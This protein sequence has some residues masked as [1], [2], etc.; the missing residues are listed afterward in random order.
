MSILVDL[1]RLEAALA[2]FGAGYLLTASPEGAVKAVTV[3]PRYAGGR[4][5][6]AGSRGS[7]ANLAAN[8]K[9]TVILPPLEARGYTL[10]ID[11]TAATSGEGIEFTP[12]SAVLHRPASHSDGPVAPG[13]CGHDCAP[14]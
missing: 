1:D 7:S 2:D 11:G 10:I 8:S 14:V 3:E 4:L 13:S 5:V 9:A 12:A 6:V